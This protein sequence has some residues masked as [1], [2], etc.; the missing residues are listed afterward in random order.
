M[1]KKLYRAVFVSLIMILS[2]LAGCIAGS[3]EDTEEIVIGDEYY[4]KIMT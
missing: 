4:G 2:S 3:D 1:S